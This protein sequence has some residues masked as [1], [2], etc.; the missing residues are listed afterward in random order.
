M[1]EVVLRRNLAIVHLHVYIHKYTCVPTSA[2]IPASVPMYP[3]VHI[4]I[5]KCIHISTSVSIYP[6]VYPYIHNCTYISTT[7]PIYLQL[8]LYCF[9]YRGVSGCSEYA[10]S[11]VS[12]EIDGYALMLVKEEHLV[13]GLKMKLGPALKLVGKVNQLKAE[14]LGNICST[15]FTQR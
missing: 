3:Q 4:Y 5:H 9:I 6:Q 1:K 7:V 15:D 13:V 10:E 14:A 11:F 12:Q 2:P 8:Y